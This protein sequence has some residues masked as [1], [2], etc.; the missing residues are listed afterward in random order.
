MTEPNRSKVERALGAMRDEVWSELA[1]RRVA[2]RLEEALLPRERSGLGRWWWAAGVA[3][4]AGLVL[5]FVLRSASPPQAAQGEAPLGSALEP[6]RATLSDGSVVDIDRGGSI[7]VLRDEP[8]RTRVEVLAGRAE[9]EVQKRPG[10]LFVAAVRGV[11]VRVIGTH[12]STELDVTRPPGV[13]RVRVQRGV[14]EVAAPDGGRVARLNAGD[15]LEV[16]LARAPATRETADPSELPSVASAT[17]SVA[18]AF[19]GEGQPGP[20][21]SAPVVDASKLFET[22]SAARR[23][24]NALAAANAYAALLKQFPNDERTGVAALE[25]GRLRMDSLRDY[26]AAAAAFRRAFAAAPTEGIRED[27]LARLVEVLDR[28]RDQ[29]GCLAEQKRYQAR[30]PSGIHAASVRARCAKR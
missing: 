13:V 19:R 29:A 15:F 23:A 28:L 10:R 8:E 24:G 14:V 4:A 3:A 6:A 30:Y 11:E 25:L 9:F 16:S 18:S 2:K 27:A 17:P 22:A 21:P 7:R 26:P 1:H 5:V 20:L 12:F